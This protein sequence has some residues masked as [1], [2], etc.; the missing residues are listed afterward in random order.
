[1]ALGDV[2][3]R[4]HT[5]LVIRQLTEQRDAKIE[6]EREKEREKANKQTNAPGREQKSGNGDIVTKSS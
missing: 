4:V 3:A 5:I 6:I 1:M 2:L